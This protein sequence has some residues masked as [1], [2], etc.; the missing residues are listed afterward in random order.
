MHFCKDVV[1]QRNMGRQQENFHV[2]GC[3]FYIRNC[4]YCLSYLSCFYG[5]LNYL[6]VFKAHFTYHTAD[7]FIVV[8]MAISIKYVS[9]YLSG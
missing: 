1:F 9:I 7:D 8:E 4:Y 3:F 6:R 2:C 5:Y